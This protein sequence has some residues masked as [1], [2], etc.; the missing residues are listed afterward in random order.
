MKTDG[1]VCNLTSIVGQVPVPTAPV[2][3]SVS[4]AVIGLGKS[5]GT[6]Y[7]YNLFKTKV[8]TICLGLTN[9]PSYQEFKE[10]F[11]NAKENLPVQ[12]YLCKYFYTQELSLNF[13][14]LD[15]RMSQKTSHLS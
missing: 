4:N 13:Q 6:E 14:I 3:G 10:F 7:Y 1:T 12:E 8:I 11:S 9:T 5:Y 2:F 15:R